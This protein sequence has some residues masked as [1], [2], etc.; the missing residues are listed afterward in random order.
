VKARRIEPQRRQF[1]GHG[2]V[3]PPRGLR[4]LDRERLGLGAIIEPGIHG[5]TGQPCDPRLAALDGVERGLQGLP[6]GGQFVDRAAVLARGGAQV[7]QAGLD[8]VEQGRVMSQRLGSGGQLVFG[9]PASI[10]AR[11]S[12]SSASVSNGCSPA[13]RSSRRAALRKASSGES[14]PD[15]T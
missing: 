5:L 14:G 7:E 13:I 9:L 4:A 15:Q 3:E 10:I 12:A 6:P 11:S 8:P 2:L 1:G